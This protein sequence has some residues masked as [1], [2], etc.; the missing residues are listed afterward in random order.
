[1]TFLAELFQHLSPLCIGIALL[2]VLGGV[3]FV[4]LRLMSLSY[5][6][7]AKGG[8]WSVEIVPPTVAPRRSDDD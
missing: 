2:V 1:V 6:V 3:F 8:A 7:R 5:T 4:L